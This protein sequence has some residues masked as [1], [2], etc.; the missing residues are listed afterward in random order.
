MVLCTLLYFPYISCSPKTYS[1]NNFLQMN[2]IHNFTGATLDLI[3]NGI[4]SLLVESFLEPLVSIDCYNPAL[5]LTFFQVQKISCLD[6]THSYFNFNKS[7]YQGIKSFLTSF[8]WDLTLTNI[9]SDSEANILFN[10]LYISIFFFTSVSKY[11][12]SSFLC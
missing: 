3:F 2:S 1:N 4:R 11:F 7:N 12:K 6:C 10:T 5:Y 9:N 8:D